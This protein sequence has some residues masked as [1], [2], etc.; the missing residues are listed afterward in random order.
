MFGLNTFGNNDFNDNK[1]G[2]K[3]MMNNND[4]FFNAFNITCIIAVLFIGVII[5]FIGNKCGN[6]NSNLK[7]K[8]YSVIDTISSTS[9]SEISDLE[10]I[11]NKY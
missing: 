1:I 3:S 10:C 7:R 2:S 8:D 9:G 4:S 6:N 11:N 5:G